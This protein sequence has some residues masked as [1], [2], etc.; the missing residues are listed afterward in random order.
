MKSS[1]ELPWALDYAP[2]FILSLRS[3]DRPY[4]PAR[5]FQINGEKAERKRTR[6]V[7]IARA[8]ISA[9]NSDHG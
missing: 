5:T 1:V 8:F 6:I 9:T 4:P 7:K 2:A 3:G